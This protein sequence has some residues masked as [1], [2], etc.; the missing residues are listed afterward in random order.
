MR[1]LG[2]DV[3]ERRIGVAVCDEEER[4]AFPLTVIERRGAARD[5]AEIDR[6]LKQERAGL[7]VVGLPLSLDGSIG[8]QARLV[9]EFVQRLEQ[10]AD[11]PVETWDERLSSAEAE[12]HLL[13]MDESR[14][15][16]RQRRDAVAAAIILQ[17]YLDSR[18]TA[19]RRSQN[20]R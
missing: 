16:R 1:M 20:E 12:R 13:A 11:V 17:S 10:Q 19:E 18:R 3:G 8:P 9:Q 7:L 14:E 6:L 15:R 4:L 5:F 2:L